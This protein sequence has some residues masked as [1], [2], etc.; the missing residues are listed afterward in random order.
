M[1][2]LLTLHP[3]I[4]ILLLLSACDSGNGNGTNTTSSDS[5][6]HSVLA[7]FA[8]TEAVTY[9]SDDP[10]FWLNPE[11]ASKSIVFGTDKDKD[12]A[13]YAFDLQGKIIED[14][15]I[16]GLKRPNNID[17]E[18][19]VDLGGETLDLLFIAERL[20][21][22]VRIYSIPDMQARD[23]G[24]I[25]V[26]TDQNCDACNELMGMAVYKN[27]QDGK[28][29]VFPGRKTGPT[30][31]TYLHQYELL[32][33]SGYFRLQ[34]VRRIGLFSGEHEIEALA[35]DDEK[36]LIYYSE[37]QVA[38]RVQHADPSKS[39]DQL[40]F[41][42]SG[43]FKKD[44]EGIAI[45][46]S[47]NGQGYIIVSDQAASKLQFFNRGDFSYQGFIQYAAIETDGIEVFS[48]AIPGVTEKGLL[49]AMS[50]DKTF[51]YYKIET[52]LEALKGE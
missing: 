9:D 13:V 48:G 40:A 5:S 46:N 41:L 31:G 49:I 30:D 44:N 12:G 25:E 32:A 47:G 34:E 27:A 4:Y 33:D 17:I 8:I 3:I 45:Y 39:A 50:D 35:V 23:N 37:E 11:D 43:L 16:R 24:G 18:Y 36:G 14:K 21:H 29:Y 20:T 1:K 22:K 26:Y 6:N 51:Q 42:G 15:V 52:I 7:P 19:G 2:D 10:A 38:V 28:V